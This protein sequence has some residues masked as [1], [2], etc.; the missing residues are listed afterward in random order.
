MELNTYWKCQDCEVTGSVPVKG[1]S[2][3]EVMHMVTADH[4][5][6]SP[7]CTSEKQFPNVSGDERERV[8]RTK[9][10]RILTR[11]KARFLLHDLSD[12]IVEDESYTEADVVFATGILDRAAKYLF[13]TEG[14]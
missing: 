14:D 7:N 5:R 6:E 10:D 12:L 8:Y 2:V 3:W 11:F 1:Q 13:T 4:K 9:T